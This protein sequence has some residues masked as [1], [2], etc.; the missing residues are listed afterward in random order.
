MRVLK[1]G[2]RLELRTDS[3]KYFWYALDTFLGDKV[4][5]TSVEIRKNEALE[6]TSKYEAR[7]LKQ[8]K[9]IYDV[10]VTSLKSSEER[11]INFNFNFKD[12]IYKKEL[13]DKITDKPLLFEGAFIHFERIFKIKDEAILIKLAFGSFDRPEHKFIYLDKKE[14]YYFHSNP[15]KTV[16][17]YR[18]H[19]KIMEYL[20][21]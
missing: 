1:K 21:V 13:L 8:E 6:V 18:T 15:V 4:A 7:W 9:D 2:G 12:I 3:Y 14:A 16:T 17:N 20:D 19:L 10:Y 5:K 11:I